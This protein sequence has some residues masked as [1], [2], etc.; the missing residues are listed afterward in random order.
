MKYIIYGII[1]IIA[2]AFFT[3]T[4]Y[5]PA[6]AFF[7]AKTGIAVSLH[8]YDDCRI[9]NLNALIAE[10]NATGKAI[11]LQLNNSLYHLITVDNNNMIIDKNKIIRTNIIF[12][13]DKKL[14]I[15]NKNYNNP[16]IL[17]ILN[18]KNYNITK[19]T[20]VKKDN[21]NQDGI[22]YIEYFLRYKR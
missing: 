5:I 16:I 8:Q 6:K 1:S 22:R 19:K 17:S 13:K 20:I 2:I 4:N 18:I 11:L 12:N 9:D 15:V 10:S 21:L 3:I 7:E 14:Q